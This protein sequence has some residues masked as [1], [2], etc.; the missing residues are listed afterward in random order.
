MKKTSC[1]GGGFLFVQMV[2]RTWTSMK[3]LTILLYLLSCSAGSV[4]QDFLS[5]PGLNE[6]NDGITSYRLLENDS[7][8]VHGLLE[9]EGALLGPSETG[10][11]L[12]NDGVHCFFGPNQEI[13]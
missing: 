13:P 2:R 4:A 1:Q 3:K 9:I 12:D 6:N 8:L 5:L 7:D 11:R 10:S